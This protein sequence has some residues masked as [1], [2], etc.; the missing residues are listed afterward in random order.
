MTSQPISRTFRPAELFLF[1]S[2]AVTTSSWAQSNPTT[3]AVM[4]VRPAARQTYTEGHRFLVRL[5]SVTGPIR[6]EQYFTLRLAVYDGSD[7]QRRLSDVQVVVA[8][9]MTHGMSEGFAHG[10]QSA[11]KVE[12]HDG[13]ATISGLFFH[14]TGDW[15]LRVTVHEAE[16]EG[17]ASFQLPCC[18]Q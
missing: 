18:E 17:T 8:A 4:H 6:L 14:M 1:M 11:A 7:P 13:V 10:M 9:G 12:M 16:E 15:T 3:A 5:L 2:L